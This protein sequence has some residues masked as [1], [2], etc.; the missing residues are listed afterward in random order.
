MERIHA[1]G[2]MEVGRKHVSIYHGKDI[3]FPSE[4]I[5]FLNQLASASL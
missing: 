1:D 5:R 2:T 4:P 3:S